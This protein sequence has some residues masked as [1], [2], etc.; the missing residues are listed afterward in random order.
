MQPTEAP[1]GGSSRTLK[2]YGPLIGIVAVIAIVGGIFAFTGG[3]DDDGGDEEASD[4]AEVSEDLPEGVIP[5]SEREQ[6]DLT[7]ADFGE[8]CDPE[9]GRYAYPSPFAAECIA[10]F[11]GDN[12]GATDTGVTE[13][14]IKVVYYRAPDVDPIID[15]ITGA[16][17]A[18]NTNAEAFETAQGFVEFFESFTETYGRNV[19]LELYEGTGPSDDEVAAR[20][21]A[22]TIA[23]DI[24]PFMVW[25]G[26]QLTSA[27]GDELA[28]QGVPCIGCVSNQTSEWYIER[29]P[30]ILS[31]TSNSQQ[32]AVHL[33]NWL[34]R[35]VAGDPAIHAGDE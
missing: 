18:D 20:A 31:I 5:F 30:H 14:T 28:A 12:G 4:G 21:D 13:D 34:G 22:V 8:Q 19:E 2:R 24:Q 9:T 16:I 32:G 35:Q 17:D 3:G 1:S 27:F 25:G 6:F 26:P 29:A 7:E 33:A 11:E 15:Y 10:P 23:Q